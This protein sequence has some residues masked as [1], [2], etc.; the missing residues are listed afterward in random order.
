MQAC[1][2][3]VATDAD[4][5][6]ACAQYGVNGGVNSN[7]IECTIDRFSSNASPKQRVPTMSLQAGAK[8]SVFITGTSSGLGRQM[9]IVPRWPWSLVARLMGVMLTALITKLR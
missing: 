6:K 1:G 5:R 7:S 4:A 8:K 3:N 9:A 2:V